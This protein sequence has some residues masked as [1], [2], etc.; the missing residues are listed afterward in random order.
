MWVKICKVRGTI[1]DTLRELCVSYH[2]CSI[3]WQL[4]WNPT[5]FKHSFY[6]A[7][8]F[9]GSGFRAGPSRDGLFLRPCAG[10]RLGGTG[11]FG[12]GWSGGA[13]IH[14]LGL[15]IGAPQVT[16][17]CCD[18]A[19]SRHQASKNSYVVVQGFRCEC[20]SRQHGNC[21]A[22]YGLVLEVT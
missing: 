1:S 7:Y 4:A 3:A 6:S 19:S 16:F 5:G 8:G 9:C 15:H 10:K 12:T 2:P 17:S 13:F 20:S 21:P 11:W 22:F 14:R 18:V